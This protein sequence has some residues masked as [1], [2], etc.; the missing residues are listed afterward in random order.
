MSLIK[1]EDE[2]RRDYILQ[3]DKTTKRTGG[4]VAVM[5]IILTSA[6]IISGLVFKWF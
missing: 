2:K 4:F 1:D 6:V 5:L 3:K